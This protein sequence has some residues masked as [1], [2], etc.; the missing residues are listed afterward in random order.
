MCR[1]PHSYSKRLALQRLQTTSF[2]ASLIYRCKLDDELSYFESSFNNLRQFENADKFVIG[3]EISLKVFL[4]DK[5]FL[6]S[7]EFFQRLKIFYEKKISILE[8]VMNPLN[9]D[10]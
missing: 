9:I 6:M 3:K 8:Q 7:E 1:A 5:D 10:I 4:A 2:I